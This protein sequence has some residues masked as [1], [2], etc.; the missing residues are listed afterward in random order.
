MTKKV[1]ILEGEIARTLGNT[2][3][4]KI[5]LVK[6]G[7]SLWI[8]EDTVTTKTK[9]ISKNGTYRAKDDDCYGYSSVSVRVPGSKVTG[10]GPDGY[11]YEVSEELDPDGNPTGNLIRKKVPSAIQIVRPPYRTNYED[12]QTISFDG[13]SVVLLDKKGGRFTSDEYPNGVVPF[14]ELDFPVTVADAS[15]VDESASISDTTGFHNSTVKA[16]PI[17]Y[18]P[19]AGVTREGYGEWPEGGYW[20]GTMEMVLKPGTTSYDYI[21]TSTVY[22]D[23][24]SSTHPVYVFGAETD[25]LSSRRQ[26]RYHVVSKGPFSFEEHRCNKW[27]NF[28]GVFTSSHEVEFGEDVYIT[29]IGAT[30][31]IVSAPV[32]SNLGAGEWYSA[33]ELA[34]VVLY[35][36]LRHGGSTSIPVQWS[37][38]TKLEDSFNINVTASSGGWNDSGDGYSDSGG[39][40]F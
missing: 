27:G 34:Y 25:P 5:P 39:G 30:I 19:L 33:T 6:G 35:G 23:N 20:G 8:P 1:A 22:I 3:K 40:T 28:G 4:L 37:K 10:E 9:S 29:S 2:K 24:I 26:F 7:T 18:C 38:N 11:D 16:L 15:A 14:G 13:I 12:G 32:D 36:D 31:D 21:R 17:P